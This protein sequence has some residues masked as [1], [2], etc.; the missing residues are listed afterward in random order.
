VVGMCTELG[1]LAAGTV[2]DARLDAERRVE[3]DT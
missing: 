3:L 1:G 2:A